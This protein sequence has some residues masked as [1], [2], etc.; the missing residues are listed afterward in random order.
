MNSKRCQAAVE[1]LMAY[2]W[3]L[4]IVIIAGSAIFYFGVPKGDKLQIERCQLQIPFNCADASVKNGKVMMRIDYNGAEDIDN[5]NTILIDLDTK[6]INQCILVKT[7]QA[8]E[9]VIVECNHTSTSVIRAE[10][11]LSYD[12]RGSGLHHIDT[13]SI[14][15]NVQ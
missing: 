15:A 7:L 1:F 14:I 6:E 11:R 13:G 5:L 12:K 9:S 4:V 2:G 8:G 10:V 3:T